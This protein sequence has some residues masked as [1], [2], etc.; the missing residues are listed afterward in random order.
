MELTDF[1][2]GMFLGGGCGIVLGICL[3]AIYLDL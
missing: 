3:T 2:M 1:A